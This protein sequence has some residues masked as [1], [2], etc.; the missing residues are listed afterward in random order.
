[1][2]PRM[3]RSEQ[4]SRGTDPREG[5]ETMAK[6][7]GA[8]G[9]E[10]ESVV[11]AQPAPDLAWDA[12]VTEVALERGWDAEPCLVDW[13]GS[14]RLDLLVTCGG[15]HRR[16]T[17]WLYRRVS[18]IGS[19]RLPIFDE[20]TRIPALDDLRCL[21]PLPNERASRFELVALSEDGLVHLPNDGNR[22]E[23]AF[24]RVV[25]L[26][27]DAE[28]GFG[29][30]Q[31][32][33]LAAFDWDQDGRT[34][35]LVGLNDLE[36]YWP[37][38]NRLPRWQQVGLNQRG[39]HPGYDL[40]GLWRGRPPMGR[41]AWLRNVGRPG[42]PRFEPQADI[43]GEHGPLDLDL[44]PAPLAVA[45]VARGAAELL[46]SDRRGLLRIYRNFGGQFPP[47]LME[48]RTLQHS[49]A[50]VVLPD[51]RTTMAVGDLDGDQ[52]SE[53]VFGTAG[54]RVFAVR[55]GANRN[56]ARAPE[57]LRQR[58]GAVILGG[59]AAVRAADLDA[60][61]DLDLVY[62]DALGRLH[63][64]EDL[65][66]G[67]D[68]RYAPPVTLEGGGLPLRIEPGPDGMM[69][70]PV[71]HGLGFARPT[72][73]DWLD[74]GRPDLIVSGAGGDVF[75]LP[76]DGA[77]TQPRFGRPHVM[78]CDGQPLIL[79]PRVQPAV[80]CWTDPE[81]L[82]LIGLNLQGFLC[83]YPRLG[84]HEVG[85]PVPIC[86]RLGRTIRLDGGFAMAG[87]VSIWAGPWTRENQID[88]LIGIAR[89]NRHVIPGVTGTPLDRLRT[90]PTVLLLE[91]LG[92]GAVAPRPMRYRGGEPVLIGQEG[93]C[94]QGVPRSGRPFP[95]LLVGS[96][97]GTLHWILR[98]ELCWE[99]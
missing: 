39:G 48:P 25:P 74:H 4:A 55:G 24:G 7:E 52:R 78:E 90:L 69:L 27:L 95:D 64:V 26:G 65:G 62:G 88:L 51:D 58:P 84:P 11:E 98:E 20:G 2:L 36:D 15:G 85:R 77:P 75:L 92:P 35:L 21:C 70:G 67:D 93:C 18:E 6:V 29:P 72:V 56:E 66:S 43:C 89:G 82:D 61:G 53:L 45:W 47:V 83:V 96:D 23:P 68:H 49:G 28:L 16:R 12:S 22:C 87:R 8:I 41:I 17:A 34:D 10:S 13:D 31:V 46:V 57:A 59:H 73:A 60:D 91:R 76:N 14:G 97:D 32:V 42:E 40:R 81:N 71:G 37:E 63:Y 86:D 50:H 79:A 44:H 5:E 3:A 9:T 99:S 54:G 33:Q 19:G 94:P 80:A 1:M 30:C 38:G